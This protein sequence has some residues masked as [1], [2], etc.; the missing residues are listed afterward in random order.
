MQTLKEHMKNDTRTK[1]IRLI[2][3]HGT[4]IETGDV[5]YIVEKYGDSIYC[6]GYSEGDGLVDI[7][8]MLKEER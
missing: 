5:N 4:R 1:R 6:N 8:V 7:W 2:D 3:W